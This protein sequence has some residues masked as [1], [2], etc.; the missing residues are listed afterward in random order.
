MSAHNSI[1]IAVYKVI[2]WSFFTSE[3]IHRELLLLINPAVY[4]INK[5]F[6]G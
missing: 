4:L 2:F 1:T 5:I 3:N 6:V